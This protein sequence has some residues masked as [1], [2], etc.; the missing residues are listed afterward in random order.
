MFLG[1]PDGVL[2]GGFTSY[3]WQSGVLTLTG[4]SGSGSSVELLWGATDVVSPSGSID[5]VAL[6]AGRPNPFG[7]G[8]VAELALPRAST[9]FLEVLDVTGRRVRLL[10]DERFDAG[11]HRMEWDGRDS[12][13]RDVANGVYFL[14]LTT[15][16]ETLTTKAVRIR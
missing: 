2:G 13:G 11:V 3:Q 6:S 10:S 7:R 12:Y 14:R 1:E 5:R 9:V 16:G 15:M 8:T 4:F